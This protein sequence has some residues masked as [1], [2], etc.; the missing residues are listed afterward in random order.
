MSRL[1]PRATASTGDGSSPALAPL[2]SQPLS[3]SPA[4]T[5][6]PIDIGG[7]AD[8]GLPGPAGAV[9]QI[10]VPAGYYDVFLTFAFVKP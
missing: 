1:A 2:L 10:A 8:C 7:L 9:N 5:P 3:S 4:Y 6:F